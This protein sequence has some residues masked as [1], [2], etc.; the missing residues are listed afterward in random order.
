MAENREKI[1]PMLTGMQVGEFHEFPI[2]QLK[3][4]RTQASELGAILDRKFTTFTDRVKRVINIK[5]IR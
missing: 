5:R 3:S 2:E 4:V 1:R